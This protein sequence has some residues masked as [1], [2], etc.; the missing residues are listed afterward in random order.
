VTGLLS[1][2]AP[3]PQADDRVFGVVVA[4]VT[5]NKD[6][7]KLGR[8]KLRFPW[9]SDTDE[10]N[11]ARVVTPMAGKSRGLYLLPEVDDEVLVCFE[12]GRIDYPCVLGALWNG[13]DTPPGDN[14][15]GKNNLRVLKSRSGHTITLDDT[16][17]AE[18]IIIQD[19][20]GKNMIQMDSANNTVEI[21]SGKD[22]SI[23]AKGKITIK[24]S[25]DLAIECN[26]FALEAKTYEIKGTNATLEAT[27][28][29]AIK[30]MAGVKINDGALEVT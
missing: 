13:K 1:E 14:S 22:L 17:G 28:G 18:K 5:N 25:A 30:C 7:D 16:D 12:H 20:T 24:A 3:T 19:K 21:A 15:D 9:L 29:M 11:W 26:K 8:V 10:S 27:G 4:I 23:T 6:P 2:L